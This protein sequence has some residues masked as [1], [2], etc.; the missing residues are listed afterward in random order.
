MREGGQVEKLVA[1]LSNISVPLPFVP[2]K[3][4]LAGR[5]L[6]RW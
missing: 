1:E 5:F 6:L 4:L 3:Y 2:L